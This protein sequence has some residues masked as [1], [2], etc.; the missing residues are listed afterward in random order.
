[1][2]NKNDLKSFCLHSNILEVE[3]PALYSAMQSESDWLMIQAGIVSEIHPYVCGRVEGDITRSQDAAICG[4]PE[5]PHTADLFDLPSKKFAPTDWYEMMK[6]IY[7][8]HPDYAKEREEK[9]KKEAK[10]KAK[11]SDE[12]INDASRLAE[13]PHLDLSNAGFDV[14]VDE[15]IEKEVQQ[16]RDV[17]GRFRSGYEIN[18]VFT[19]GIVFLMINNYFCRI[20]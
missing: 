5:V 3:R 9:K 17:G 12:T 19:I 13:N 4:Q 16:H 11:E 7:E 8:T 10:K 18:T 2:E 15:E 1:M 20:S 6:E 14:I